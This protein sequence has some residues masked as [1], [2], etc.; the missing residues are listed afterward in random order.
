ME[1]QIGTK[2][3]GKS[4]NNMNSRLAWFSRDLRKL[5]IPENDFAKRLPLR[6]V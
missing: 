3:S 2:A 6:F 1:F 4:E 5:K